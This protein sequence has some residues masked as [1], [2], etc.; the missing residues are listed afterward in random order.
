MKEPTEHDVRFRI[1]YSLWLEEMTETLNRRLDTFINAV[2][3]TL[4]AS[5]FAASH[6]SWLFG[7]VIAVLSGCRVAWQFGRVAGSARQQR[8]RYAV[9][10]DDAA[11]LDVTEMRGR[12]AMLEEFDSPVLGGLKNPAWHRACISLNI[13]NNEKLTYMEKVISWLAGGIPR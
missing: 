1:W 8:R 11:T 9:L 7:G 10:A 2:T 12:L 3:L 5:I 6:F 4:G 13:K